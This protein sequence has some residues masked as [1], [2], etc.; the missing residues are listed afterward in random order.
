MTVYR[1]DEFASDFNK[2]SAD[3]K[4]AALA[5]LFGLCE[6][7]IADTVLDKTSLLTS[8]SELK[9]LQINNHS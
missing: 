5:Q 2:L 6:F 9:A 4:L 7:S 8:E 3:N 1:F